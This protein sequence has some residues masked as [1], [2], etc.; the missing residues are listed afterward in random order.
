MT[1]A[2]LRVPMKSC[3]LNEARL[4][5][6]L[7]QAIEYGVKSFAPAEGLFQ[8]AI[9]GGKIRFMESR[10]VTSASVACQSSTCLS[11]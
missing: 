5:R 8:T 9:G 2:R 3:E 6:S 4:R 11:W 1:L 10:Q 7:R